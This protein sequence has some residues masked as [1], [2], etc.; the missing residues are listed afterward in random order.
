[1]QIAEYPYTVV[2]KANNKVSGE[3]TQLINEGE[4]HE[5]HALVN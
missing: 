1:M 3:G 4:K 5:F 2:E